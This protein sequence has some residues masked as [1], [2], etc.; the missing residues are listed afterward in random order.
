MT[1]KYNNNKG[2]KF[3]VDVKLMQ[4]DKI[5][6]QI[7]IFSTQS[8][9]LARKKLM[10]PY[11]HAGIITPFDFN[12]LEEGVTNIIKI[13]YKDS[14]IGEFKQEDMIEIVDIFMMQEAPVININVSDEY[15]VYTHVSV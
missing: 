6:V 13:M 1:I 8:A 11:S 2:M 9:S 5:S 15:D 4:E 12:S 14:P 3:I 7:Q 10:I